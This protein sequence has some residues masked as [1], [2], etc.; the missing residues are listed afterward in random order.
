MKWVV[1]GVFAAAFALSGTVASDSSFAGG[2]KK[3]GSSATGGGHRS[4]RHYRRGPK[5]RGFV[6][7][8]GGYSYSIDDTINTY[9]DSRTLNGGANS[10]RF[11]LYTRQTPSGPFDHGFFFDSGMG[12][13]GGDSPYLN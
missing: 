13:H 12:L 11:E 1:A 8:R 2:W 9:R 7:R 10:Y 3:R 6:K 5:V 4:S